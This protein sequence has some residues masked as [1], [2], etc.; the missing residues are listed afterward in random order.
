M[1]PRNNRTHHKYLLISVV[2]ILSSCFGGKQE[3]EYTPWGTV[4]GEAAYD[5]LPDGALS[6]GDILSQGEMI[7]LTL[8]G[9]ET[10]Y[11][12]HGHGMGLHFMLC[13]KFAQHIGV[14]LRVEVCKDTLD[15]IGRLLRNEGDIIACPVKGDSLASCGPQWAVSRDNPSLLHEV[16]KWYRA[17]MVAEVKRQ[18][19]ELLA[20]GGVTRKVYAPIISREKGLISRWDPLFKKY[21]VVPRLDW[22]LL[23]AQCYQESCFDPKAH[24]W[25]GACGL[26]QIMPSTASLLG[27]QQK[28]I[29]DPEKNIE[30]AARYMSQLMRDFHDVDSQYDR[31]CFALAS[32][33]GGKLHIRDAMALARKDG[34]DAMKWAVVGQY[35]LKLTQPRYYT[36]PVVAY[37]YMRGTETYDYVERIMKRWKDYGG[38]PLRGSS[39]GMYDGP[40]T[41]PV[42]DNSGAMPRPAKKKH[43][44]SE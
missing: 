15:M 16:R 35:V 7:M 6:V 4:V 5:S 23:A 12:Y 14:K 33:N 9:P 22:K 29:Y 8:N 39:P 31:I 42:I 1:A 21:A 34:R 27:L 13:E 24:S 36:D 30:A 17:D 2:I 28:D 3:Q 10:Y 37:G 11:D 18:Q 20:S 44:F 38:R 19:K 40:S 32:Y 26:M 25:A 43:R 41:Q